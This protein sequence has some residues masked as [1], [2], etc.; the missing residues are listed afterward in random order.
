MPAG[1]RRRFAYDDWANEQMLHV[2]LENS[3][4]PAMTI[5]WMSHILAG[6][7]LWLERLTLRPQSHPVWPEWSLDDCSRQGLGT[8]AAWRD[9]LGELDPSSLLLD[10]AY[11]NSNGERFASQV[12]DILDH[13][14]LH[15]A[16]HR[17]QITSA[18]RH[19]SIEPP[20]TDLIHAT[21]NG[22]LET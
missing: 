22:F 10:V 7:W 2:L 19:A 14:L 8:A 20:Y 9:Y 16:Y 18:L 5:R 17:G 15:G 4:R 6:R 11:T 3:P 13:V 12:G 1:Y 21:R